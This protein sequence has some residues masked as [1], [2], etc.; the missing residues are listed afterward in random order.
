MSVHPLLAKCPVISRPE[1]AARSAPSAR[2]AALD[3]APPTSSATPARRSLARPLVA[4]TAGAVGLL[5]YNWWVLVP[6]KPGLLRSPDEFFSNLE[7]TGYPY[8]TLMQHADVLAGI[9]LLVAFVAAGSRNVPATRREWLGMMIFA[10]A[11]SVGGM[12]PQ[13]CSDGISARCLSLEWQFRLPATQYVHDGAGIVE[14]TAITL[15]LWLAAARAR[16]E[17]S[18][19][20]SAY[21][22]LAIGVGVAYPFLF[23]AYLLDRLG[24]V[25][26]AVFFVGFA[27]MVLTQLAERTRHRHDR[28]GIVCDRLPGTPERQAVAERDPAAQREGVVEVTESRLRV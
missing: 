26:E 11:G 27:M 19:V 14:F 12:F 16:R 7:V 25:V 23:L 15:T 21:R 10:L 20:A 2:P 8:A 4:W 24:A 22:W 3:A 6:L 18:L 13:T 5:A 9:F 28:R 1:V 17:R